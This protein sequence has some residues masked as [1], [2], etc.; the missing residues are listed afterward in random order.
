[1]GLTGYLCASTA[2]APYCDV[3]HAGRFWSKWSNTSLHVSSS[4]ALLNTVLA[5]M[6]HLQEPLDVIV[7]K[8]G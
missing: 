3:A 6:D 4:L 5:S 1:M 7:I 2:H 8:R